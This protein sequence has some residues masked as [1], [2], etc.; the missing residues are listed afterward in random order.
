MIYTDNQSAIRFIEI[1]ASSERTKH[2]ALRKQFIQD[3]IESG[4]IRFSYVPPPTRSN[5]ADC[6]TKPVEASKLIDQSKALGLTD[7]GGCCRDL[8]ITVFLPPHVAPLVSGLRTLVEHVI[9][10]WIIN[11]LVSYVITMT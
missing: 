3:V 7:Q 10:P 11:E 6:L 9:E 8:I 2:M 4:Q 1:Q 5:I